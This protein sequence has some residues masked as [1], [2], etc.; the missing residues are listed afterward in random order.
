MKAV[1]IAGYGDPDVMQVGE[2]PD[3]VAGPGQIRVRVAAAAVNPVDLMVRS[4]RASGAVPDPDFPLVL[5]WDAAGVVD[6]VGDGVTA[7]ETG[8]RVMG[9]SLWFQGRRG[10]Y[11]EHVVLEEQAA[12][13]IPDGIDDASACTL[14][15][16]GL[17]AWSALAVA[18]PEAGSRLLVT[19]GAGAVGGYAIQLAVARGL[20]VVALGRA[21]DTEAMSDFGAEVATDDPSKVEPVDVAIDTTGKAGEFLGLV[22]PGGRVVTIAGGTGPDTGEVTVKG[23]GVRYDSAGLAELARMAGEGSITLRVAETMGVAEAPRAHE[24]MAAGGVRGRLVLHN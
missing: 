4:G 19:G 20:R 18:R 5:G 21:I 10:T 14:P 6:Q 23:V 7:F 1:V 22:R 13:R 9:M 16:N 15:L 8:D 11:A 2:I 17:T 24:L 12:A 3:P